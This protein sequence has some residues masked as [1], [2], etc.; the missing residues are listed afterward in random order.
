LL[1]IFTR[2]A[3]DQ[4]PEAVILTGYIRLFVNEKSSTVRSLIALLF[5]SIFSFSIALAQDNDTSGW[6]P[7][8]TADDLSPSVIDATDW[9]D[10]PAGKHGWLKMDGDRFVFEDGT[11]IKFWGVNLADYRVFVD[12]QEAQRW[13][14]FLAKYGVN[15]VRF[16]K[17]TRPGYAGLPVS[18]VLDSTKFDQLDYFKARLREKGIYYGWSHIFGH[19]LRPG[20]R[21]RVLAYDEVEA[22]GSTIG[23]VMFAPDL[24]DLMIELTVNML[25]HVNPYTGLRYAED[26]ALVFVELQ[27]E[28]DIFFPTTVNAVDRAPTY[29]KLFE[30]L[31]SDW[32]RQRYG[33]HEALVKAW[34]EQA[35][36]AFPKQQTGEHLDKDNI[37]PM[38]NGWTL[39]IGAREQPHLQRRLLDTARFLYE[40]QNDFYERY[41]AAIRATGYKGPILTTPWQAGEGI[42]HYYNLH[43]DALFG[44][45]DRHNYYG[46]GAGRHD[47][48]PGPLTDGG[49][50]MVQNPGSG[51][52][53]TGMQQVDGRPFVLSEWMSMVP[54]EWTA[55]AAP[56]LAV[57]GMGLQGWDGSYAYAS[58][59]SSITEVVQAPRHGY[60]N[61]ESPLHLTLY[62]TLARMIY[63]GDVQE[64]NVLSYRNVHVPSLLA[65]WIG[66]DE[67]VRQDNDV[68]TFT[69]TI[70]AF[71][72]AAG[73]QV[74]RF[75]DAYQPTHAPDLSRYVDEARKV[76]HSSTGQ[77]SWHYG[78]DGYF[79]VNTPG[80]QAVV[81]FAGGKEHRLGNVTVE[82]SNP[83]IVLFVTSLDEK[84]PIASSDRL[85]VTTVARARNTGMVYNE[86][87]TE[88]LSVGEA[89]VLM[90]PVK[91]TLRL[92]R[93]DDAVVHVLDHAGRRTGKTIRPRNGR[94]EL[95]GA[96]HKTIY[97]EIEFL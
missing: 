11:P 93:T 90:E 75:T 56:L 66:F 43:S 59:Q 42:A 41:T 96:R 27:N 13:T 29:K 52:F 38:A 21:N 64:A 81:G 85:L 47:I 19:Q 83:F 35:I 28:D 32:L 53:G 40:V 86:D 4:S 57:Y 54:N 62:P 78:E 2:S 92:N 45:I 80:T 76:I 69:G 82:T 63:R 71:G 91:A 89:P 55:E 12:Q 34:G 20:D 15:A 94:I 51:L 58:N 97:Y 26:P 17:F 72:M 23:L 7:F 60:Y 9:L 22:L 24:Q 25:N 73:R 14:D 70:D 18:T 46:G 77:L 5:L 49:A 87:R 61:V 31:F 16:H 1:V 10:A 50:A 37:Y 3:K 95:D 88:L 36:D 84:A 39:G 33:T 79:T 30:K 65:G 6:F 68:K 48:E 74:V 8:D 67:S 44:F